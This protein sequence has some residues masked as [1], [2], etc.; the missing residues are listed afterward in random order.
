MLV[1]DSPISFEDE[2]DKDGRCCAEVI[3][4][5]IK[6]EDHEKRLDQGDSR[7]TRIEGK[8]DHLIFLQ[9]GALIAGVSALAIGILKL[10]GM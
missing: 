2:M 4:A 8:L 6:V 3:E 5:G 10:K 1:F 7:M 9:Y